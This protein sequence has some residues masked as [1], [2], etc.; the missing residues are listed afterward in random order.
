MLLLQLCT[1]VLI[2]SVL[3]W[4]MCMLD[5][6]GRHNLQQKTWNRNILLTKLLKKKEDF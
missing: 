1:C 5:S 6:Y 2:Y 3:G 4:T